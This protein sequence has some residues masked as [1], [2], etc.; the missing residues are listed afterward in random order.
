MRR[1]L[2]RLQREWKRQG[3]ACLD[4]G[5]GLASGEVMVGQ[6]GSPRRM[7][8]TVIGD[9][10]NL[11]ARLEALT[12]RLDAAVIFDRRTAA[13]LAGDPLLAVEPLGEQEVKGLGRVAVFSACEAADPVQKLY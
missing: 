2:G 11:A 8:F 1:A 7:E 13:L 3:I 4:N 9:T 10:V 5:V 12:R 6:I